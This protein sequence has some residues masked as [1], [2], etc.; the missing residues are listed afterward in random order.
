MKKVN[1]G[2]LGVQ[3]DVEEHVASVESAFREITI[4]GIVSI[5]K[6]SEEIDFINGLI[7]PGGESTSIGKL[8]NNDD[9]HSS[10]K[11]KITQ[12][13]PVLGTC[14]GL[15]FLSNHIIQNTKDM[16]DWFIPLVNRIT[17]EGKIKDKNYEPIKPVNPHK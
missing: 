15:I 8:S 10:I 17:E 9:F 6:Y 11:K 5:I 3:G 2:I 1:I 4:D 13:M 14:A 12:G 7:I 16:P